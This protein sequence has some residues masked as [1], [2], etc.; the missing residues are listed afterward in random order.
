MIFREFWA[1]SLHRPLLTAHHLSY[2]FFLRSSLC[3][4]MWYAWLSYVVTI[5]VIFVKIFSNKMYGD[6][7]E[8]IEMHQRRRPRDPPSPAVS[9]RPI[10]P[11]RLR[12]TLQSPSPSRSA[13]SVRAS[14]PRPCHPGP[15]SA[16]LCLLGAPQPRRRKVPLLPS[17]V[18]DVRDTAAVR[19]GGR[20]CHRCQGLKT[21]VIDF[22]TW[23]CLQE[24][25][26]RVD[27]NAENFDSSFPKD[28][29]PT[30]CQVW[31]LSLTTCSL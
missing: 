24:A 16:D 27:A 30:V 3:N 20:N 18:E 14:T 23:T 26:F 5:C 11:T 6:L 4:F 21:W 22:C 25:I 10:I 7:K 19:R 2:F 12:P 28:D 17:A 8:K 13:A 1:S 15:R 31:S 9:P 29:K